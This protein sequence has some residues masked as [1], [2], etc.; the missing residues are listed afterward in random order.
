MKVQDLIIIKQKEGLKMNSSI[1]RSMAAVLTAS[2]FA[3]CIFTVKGPANISSAKETDSINKI[4]TA[5][6]EE[7]PI[8]NDLLINDRVPLGEDMSDDGTVSDQDTF[9]ERILFDDT[10]ATASL[11]KSF[12]D[13][14]LIEPASCLLYTSRCV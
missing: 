1:S 10:K 12:T 8:E 7:Y 2:I 3:L 11:K 4:Y 9:D 13:N 6:K 14:M 5:T